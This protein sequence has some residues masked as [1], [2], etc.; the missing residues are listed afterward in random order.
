VHE[1]P[2]VKS[3]RITNG[4]GNIVSTVELDP[5]GG[6]TSRNNNDAFQPRKFTTY[7]R[8]G[9][10]SDEAVFRR[11]NRWWSRFDQPDPY[12][13]SYDF[14]NPQS[15]NRYAYVQNDPVNFVDPT[16]LDPCTDENGNPIDCGPKDVD[17]TVIDTWAPYLF[18]PYF[19]PA[20]ISGG[21]DIF[22]T[23]TQPKNPQYPGKPKKKL[24]PSHRECQELAKK[25]DNILRDLQGK[26]QDILDDKLELPLDGP[27]SPKTTINGQLDGWR[28]N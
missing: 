9:N 2:I 26:S 10:A 7:E 18:S 23:L 14:T 22:V 12:D 8:D 1:D 4:S 3:K 28:W 27:G 15:F 25:I 24:D 11:Y 17:V 13:G 5:W 20:S 21:S 19:I 16:G 6:N